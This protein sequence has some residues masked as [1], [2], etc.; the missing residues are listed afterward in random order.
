MFKKSLLTILGLMLSLAAYAQSTIK[1]KFSEPDDVFWDNRFGSYGT[2]GTIYDIEQ[3]NDDTLFVAGDFMVI[4]G[5]NAPYLGMWDGYEWKS[6]PENNDQAIS[7]GY[8]AAVKYVGGK[9]YILNQVDQFANFGEDS[10]GSILV[11][12]PVNDHIEKIS[13]AS[14]TDPV[15]FTGLAVNVDNKVF[16]VSNLQNEDDTYSGGLYSVVDQG[17]GSYVYTA[18]SATFSGNSTPVEVDAIWHSIVFFP[19]DGTIS[20]YYSGQD[21]TNAKLAMFDV[22]TEAM[23]FPDVASRYNDIFD[24]DPIYDGLM[25]SGTSDTRP[26]SYSCLD[27]YT[28]S[29]DSWENFWYFNGHIHTKIAAYSKE[30]FTLY[31]EP[32]PDLLLYT[33]HL[34]TSLNGSD[35]TTHEL[36]SKSTESIQV[37]DL[38]ETE[39]YTI[40]GGAFAIKNAEIPTFD[41]VRI[42][43]ADYYQLHPVANMSG[44]DGNVY[45]MAEREGA[46]LAGG[47]FD[48]AGEV[49]TPGL[50]LIYND[51]WSSIGKIMKESGAGGTVYSLMVYDKY[52]FVGGNFDRIEHNGFTYEVN[53]VAQ[54]NFETDRWNTMAGGLPGA[55]SSVTDFA[56]NGNNLFALSGNKL[57][58][59]DGQTWHEF[60]N[61][62][63]NSSINDGSYITDITVLNNSLYAFGD[64]TL[65]KDGTQ[66]NYSSWLFRFDQDEI[67]FIFPPDLISENEV[68]TA[69]FSVIDD[70]VIISFPRLLDF[71]GTGWEP[72]PLYVVDKDSLREFIPSP[73]SY[74]SNIIGSGDRLFAY[75]YSNGAGTT[76]FNG[77]TSWNGESW[78]T[79]GSGVHDEL[80]NTNRNGFNTSVN[81]ALIRQDGVL[82]VGGNFYL[83]GNKPSSNFAMWNG[84]TAPSVP[85]PISFEQRQF[86]EYSESLRF[87]WR[88]ANYSSEFEFELSE[89][90]NFN[91]IL[92]GITGITQNEVE[93]RTNFEPG[94]TY[95]WRVR[96]LNPNGVSGWSE[97]STFEMVSTVSNETES[98]TGEFSLHQNYPNPFN[99]NT[100]IGYHLPQSSLV[101]LSVYDALGREIAKLVQGRQSEGVHKVTFDASALA[102]GVYF[103]RIEAGSFN[104]LKK[105]LLIK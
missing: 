30:K 88:K 12:D 4:N 81:T 23:R 71:N 37:N 70:E 99:P 26:C 82:A 21:S 48:F 16:A 84:E 2:N 72:V 79:L 98:V 103:Y 58:R 90:E 3:V 56:K 97:V 35:V 8:I 78:E 61:I 24:V 57:K 25:I 40:P 34:I 49:H 96:A 93:V 18:T 94:V 13:S 74:P 38:V 100:V 28:Y 92:V 86:L 105:M 104:Q 29:T 64:I 80:L 14:G 10:K 19:L 11:Y 52:L 69:T 75:N 7:S 20:E 102:S 9:L 63:L 6:I 27:F 41:M 15:N 47:N 67:A 101:T 59:Y 77:I 46:L 39:H 33:Q 43:G 17:N 31:S 5:A 45:A 32:N 91:S 95:Y 36:G 73:S 55:L 60:T 76:G 54:Y 62:G 85:E 65:T 51:E 42:E 22:S 44:F 66:Y 83:A 50:A 87:R 68:S 89:Q 1:M 53:N